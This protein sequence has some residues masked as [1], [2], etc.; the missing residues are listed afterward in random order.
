MSGQLSRLTTPVTGVLFV[1]LTLVS[2]ATGGSTPDSNASGAHVIAFYEA[3]R[4]SQR[5]SNILFVFAALF[6]VFFAGSV[7]GYL[8]RAPGAHRSECDPRAREHK[9][10]PEHIAHHP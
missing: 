9:G 2:I 6:L 3:H 7:H 4:H 1:G 8:R 10:L 5:V